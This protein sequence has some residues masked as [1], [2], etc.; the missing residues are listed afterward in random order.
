MLGTPGSQTR[1]SRIWE[2]LLC[3]NLEPRRADGAGSCAF[4]KLGGIILHLRDSKFRL[5]PEAK[6]LLKERGVRA[7]LELAVGSRVVFWTWFLSREGNLGQAISDTT[8]ADFL[9]DCHVR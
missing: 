2:R 3:L 1:P 7:E 8:V 4:S 9:I 5:F 6:Q